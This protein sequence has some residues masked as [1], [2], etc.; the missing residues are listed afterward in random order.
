[1]RNL[2][3]RLPALWQS[4]YA[5][6]LVLIV[7][8]QGTVLVSQAVAAIFF[9]P[10]FIG[11]IRTFESGFSVM[12]LIAGFGAPGLAIR[13]L[14]ASRHDPELAG[15]Q[16]RNL[17][18]LPVMGAV[19]ALVV[20]VPLQHVAHPAFSI[21]FLS[22]AAAALLLALVN[23]VRLLSAVGQAIGATRTIAFAVLVGA[24]LSGMAHLAGALGGTLESWLMGRVAGETI[25]LIFLIMSFRRFLPTSAGWRFHSTRFLRLIAR[26]TTV[27]LGLI[28]RMAADSAPILMLGFAVAAAVHAGTGDE[29]ALRSNVGYFGIA[30][31][32]LSLGMLPISVVCQQAIP[33]LT[34]AESGD[35]RLTIRRATLLRA[36]A[37]ALSGALLIGMALLI[38]TLVGL[39]DWAAASAALAL[40]PSLFLKA[41]AATCG[42]VL[43]ASDRLSPP[44]WV[45]LAELGA[46]AGVFAC[47]DQAYG[48]SVA[49]VATLIGS[50]IS[51]GGM[52]MIEL[53][54]A[55]K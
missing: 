55:K 16:F 10:V 38:L 11:K 1:V 23:T 4:E 17:I 30:T 24:M 15:T 2:L 39:V 35:D 43:L 36:V 53:T 33:Y 40:L 19:I 41:I 3:Q 12:L 54:G 46:I 37:V 50:V 44:M 13:E 22:L 20:A 7:S 14:A 27:N 5:A 32:L 29:I 47:A 51:A 49:V 52:L 21:G 31:L 28:T 45:N 25:L 6:L 42:S 9:D 34:R 26:S 18:L 48:V 8:I